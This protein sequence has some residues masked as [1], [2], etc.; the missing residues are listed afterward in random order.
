MATSTHFKDAELKCPCCNENRVTEDFLDLLEKLRGKIGIPLY[1]TSGYRCPMHNDFVSHTGLS[2][3]HTTG[4]AVDIAISYESAF[5][6]VDYATELGF[7]G[8][9]VNQRGLIDE[10][11]IH[12]DKLTAN[13]PRI[14]SY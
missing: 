1:I 10:R 14:W 11:F 8:I 13:R 12:L 7:T 4:K 2:G 9:G 6:L 3:P 5:L